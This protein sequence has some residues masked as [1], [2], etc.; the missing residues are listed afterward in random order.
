MKA[1]VHSSKKASHDFDF[2]PLCIEAFTLIELLVVIAII[3]IL[4]ALL[5]PT[6]ASAKRMAQ[7]GACLS[8][9]KQLCIANIMYAGD[10]NGTVMQPADAS[11]PYGAKAGWVGGLIDYFA[12]S[13]NMIVCPAAKFSVS[14]AFN[15]YS[16]PGNSTGGGQPGTA[17]NAWVLYLTVKSPLGWTIPCSY[18]YNAWFYSPAAPGVNRDAPAIEASHGVGDPGWCFLKDSQIQHPTLTPVY[19]DGNWQDACP[20]E[21]DSP[22]QDLWRGT[23]WLGQRNGYEMGRMAIQRHGGISAASRSYKSNWKTSPPAG[24]VNVTEYDG[25]AEL[26]KLP[27]LWSL[28]WHRDWGQKLTPSIGLPAPY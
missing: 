8:N 20:S 26:T 3:A 17:D 21:V 14:P 24:A 1:K 6:L 16:S 10:N 9:L 11:S 22:C 13:T 12:K 25:H 19:A 28:E 18:T 5:L 15:V 27:N 23:D 7:Q 2:L 4:A